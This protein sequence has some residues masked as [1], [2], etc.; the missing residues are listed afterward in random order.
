MDRTIFSCLYVALNLSKAVV[1]SNRQH[2]S[3][4]VGKQKS[5]PRNCFMNIC[6]VCICVP[7]NRME[8]ICHNN[9]SWNFHFKLNAL[10]ILTVMF[11]W[12]IHDSTLTNYF[13]FIC[14]WFWFEK[15]SNR[16]I[17][18]F[19]Y[20]AVPTPSWFKPSGDQYEIR[21]YV[22]IWGYQC[23]LVSSVHTVSW[24]I[25]IDFFNATNV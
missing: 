9:F 6:F 12:F 22:F 24:R 15:H 23:Q 16:M 5:S 18:P 14:F 1:Q 4:I 25:Y 13:W 21:Q 3:K 11:A 7:T 19:R 2:S 17:N 20:D 8:N 10:N